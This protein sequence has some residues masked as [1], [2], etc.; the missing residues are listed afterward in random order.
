MSLL[1]ALAFQTTCAG[2]EMA[3]GTEWNISV[4]SGDRTSTVTAAN[5]NTTG[6]CPYIC[7]QCFTVPKNSLGEPEQCL[8]EGIVNRSQIDSVILVFSYGIITLPENR[9]A[10]SPSR[11]KLRWSNIYITFFHLW[12][13]LVLALDRKS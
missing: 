7:V 12:E 1:I 13:Y 10:V 2:K 4:I 8:N 6:H 11:D 5:A 9:V 3:S